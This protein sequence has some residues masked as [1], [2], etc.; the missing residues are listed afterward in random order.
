MPLLGPVDLTLRPGMRVA[1]TGAADSGQS[2]LLA[3][4]A[5][6]QSAERGTVRTAP[7]VSLGLIR[8]APAVA[9]DTTVWAHASAALAPLEGLERE[10]RRQEQQLDSPAAL[11]RYGEL[12]EAFEAAGGYR[13][14]GELRELLAAFGLPE[15]RHGQRLGSLSGGE[16]QRLELARTISLRPAILLLH[17]PAA[18]LDEQLAAQLAG[19]LAAWPGALLFSSHD[20]Q[21][22]NAVASH[23]ARLQDGRLTLRRGGFPARRRSSRPRHNAEAR[24]LLQLEDL[25]LLPGD[26]TMLAVR[27]LSVTRGEKIVLLGPNGSGKSILL[28]Q[29]ARDLHFGTAEAGISWHGRVKLHYGDQQYAGV[30]PADTPLGHLGR[31]MS[32]QR[33]RQLLGLV[34]LEPRL[35]RLPAAELDRSAL[36]RTGLATLLADESDLLLLDEPETGLDLPGIEL[37]EDTLLGAAGAV[38][39]VTHDRQL[40][41]DVASRVWAVEDGE[42]RDYRGGLDGWRGGRLRLEDGLKQAA[43]QPTEPAAADGVPTLELLEEQLAAVDAQLADPLGLGARQLQ[44]LERRQAE[45]FEALMERFDAA[46]PPPAPRYRLRDSGVTVEADLDAERSGL[47]FKHIDGWAPQLQLKAG[48]AHLRLHGPADRCLLPRTERALL[49]VATRLAFYVLNVRLVQYW[50]AQPPGG[51]LLEPAGAG[52]YALARSRFEQLEGWLTQPGRAAREPVP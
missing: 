45:L 14:E 5:G 9:A 29:L 6:E 35:Q 15:S 39:L 44:R 21:F 31:L 8:Q 16:R 49:N 48:V 27:Q 7:G 40:A 19:R 17:E 18:G 11:E 22:I 47:Q 2:E 51:L 33:A 4:L 25:R 30:A 36:A 10:L 3:V 24:Q 38:I 20:R 13:A 28:R 42:V 50:A 23:V 32:P 41:A 43:E 46:F 52:W 37:L 26:G 12:A 34:K 1:L